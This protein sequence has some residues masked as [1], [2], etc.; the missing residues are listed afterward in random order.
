MKRLHA[1]VLALVGWFLM[2]PPL[3]LRHQA[4]KPTEPTDFGLTTWEVGQLGQC[5]ETTDQR[6]TK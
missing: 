5:I 1:A 4:D 6:L 3:D 2:V